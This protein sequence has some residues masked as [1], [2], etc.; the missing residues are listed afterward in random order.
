M[1][2]LTVD[3]TAVPT[4]STYDFSIQDISEATRVASGKIVIDRID[5][6]VKLTMS[7]NYITKEDLAEFL[8]LIE[9]VTFQVTYHDPRTDSFQTR[10]FYVGDR[11]MGMFRY[12]DGVPVWKSVSFNFIEV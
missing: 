5:T 11:K 6:K 9:V 10:E 2:M 4:P 1:A 7:W 8:T 3:G 12:K